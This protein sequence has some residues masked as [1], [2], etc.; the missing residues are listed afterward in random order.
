MVYNWN[1]KHMALF[2]SSGFNSAWGPP[3]YCC[4]AYLFDIRTDSES[5]GPV[6]YKSYRIVKLLA[7]CPNLETLH[8]S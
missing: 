4:P 3:C 6:S 1:W 5:T 7:F 2:M 8:V